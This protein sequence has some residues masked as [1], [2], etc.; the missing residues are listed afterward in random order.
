MPFFINL[1]SRGCFLL[2][3]LSVPA[4]GHDTNTFS[5][6][7]LLTGSMWKTLNESWILFKRGFDECF[8][9]KQHFIVESVESCS[10]PENCGLWIADVANLWRTTRLYSYGVVRSFWGVPSGEDGK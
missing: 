4:D 2:H 3:S 10:D 9:K 8:E 7:G 5:L 1:S 6:W